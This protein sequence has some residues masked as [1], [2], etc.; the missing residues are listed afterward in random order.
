M[1][2]MMTAEMLEAAPELRAGKFLDNLVMNFILRK[3]DE[4]F[5]G[6]RE[7]LQQVSTL[8]PWSKVW[9]AIQTA[10][11]QYRAGEN[12]LSIIKTVLSEWLEITEDDAGI[13]IALKPGAE[14]VVV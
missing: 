1:S 6:S 13:R 7:F 2:A 4:Q 11:I 3:L 12:F 9:Q 14:E 10:L 5:P 8:L